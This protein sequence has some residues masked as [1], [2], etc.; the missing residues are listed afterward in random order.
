[1]YKLTTC[2]AEGNTLLRVYSIPGLSR[3]FWGFLFPSLYTV[4]PFIPISTLFYPHKFSLKNTQWQPFLA[5]SDFG[6][7]PL[8]PR[9]GSAVALLERS[10]WVRTFKPTKRLPLSFV[11]LLPLLLWLV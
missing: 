1:M 2:L 8:H 6:I 10:I 5:S 4:Y 9:S 3:K 7:P 11:L